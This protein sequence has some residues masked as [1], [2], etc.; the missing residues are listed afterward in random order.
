MNK[1]C[2]FL[3]AAS[4]AGQ[5]IS[6]TPR[7]SGVRISRRLPNK[8]VLTGTF[9]VRER[10]E[11]VERPI[12]ASANR[13]FARAAEGPH[14]LRWECQSL[15]C[16]PNKKVLMGTF[17]VRE[18]DEEVERPIFASANREFAR[19]AEGPHR[20]RWECQSLECLPNKKVPTGT[21]FVGEN[22]ARR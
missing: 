5:S 4:S 21:F 3:W 17:F 16:L 1:C 11:E 7:G 6:F 10:D 20:S 22:A 19:A 12:F 14:R 9:F 13:E 8:K 18:R 2:P 15:E